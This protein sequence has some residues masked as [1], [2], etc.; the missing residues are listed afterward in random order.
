MSEEDVGGMPQLKLITKI[1]FD[2]HQRNRG[3]LSFVLQHLSNC[4]ELYGSDFVSNFDLRNRTSY[5]DDRIS[6]KNTWEYFFDVSTD[7]NIRENTR[8][9]AWPAPVISGGRINFYGYDFNYNNTD[10]RIIAKNIIDKHA[11]FNSDILNSV[12]KFFDDKMKGFKI[13]GVHKRGTDIALHHTKMPIERYFSEIDSIISDYDY[14]FLSTDE[15]SVVETFK[16]KYKNLITF[17]SKTLSSNP[18]TPSFKLNPRKD[19]YLMGFEVI[20]ESLL[21]SKVDFLL[22]TNSNVSNFSLLY[23]PFLKY[24]NIT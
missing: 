10:E 11:R 9:G 23:N 2:G 4:R 16:S 8:C 18:R 21:L 24:K 13:L 20:I 22:K 3:L 5:F 12:N 6:N 19:G 14:V 1:P 17:N 15:E 7:L